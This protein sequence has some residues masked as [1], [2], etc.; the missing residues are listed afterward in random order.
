MD[1]LTGAFQ[2]LAAVIA[3]G[4]VAK[5]LTPD[6]SASMLRSI[7]LP[8]GTVAARLSG[9]VEVAIGLGAVLWGGRPAAAAVAAAYAVFTAVVVAARR[10]GASSCG[11]FGSVAAPP[12]GLH[13]AVNAASCLVAL[14]A[15]AAGPPSL[16]D[17]LADQPLAGVPYLVALATATWLVVVLDTTGARLLEEMTAVRALG[18]TFRENGRV[19]ATV[20]SRTVAR[21][22][23]TRRD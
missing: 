10:S 1:L 21:R 19:A 17:V 9:A 6:A 20:P 4:G 2:I 13:V 18:P 8:G 5:L 7:A 16:V 23:R 3:V 22:S 14:A 12:S 15:V 11:C